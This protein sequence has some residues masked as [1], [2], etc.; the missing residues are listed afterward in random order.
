MFCLIFWG[1]F[2]QNFLRFINLHTLHSENFEE[3]LPLKS[4]LV[5][6]NIPLRG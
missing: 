1:G 6:E 5:S 4:Q 3:Q 2:L